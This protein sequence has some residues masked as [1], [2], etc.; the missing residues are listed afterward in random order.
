M[1]IVDHKRLVN[2]HLLKADYLFLY[3]KAIVLFD[4]FIF[5]IKIVKMDMSSQEGN[6]SIQLLATCVILAPKLLL[7]YHN[8]INN[9][10]EYPTRFVIL[11]TNFTTMFSKIGHLGI[12]NMLNKAKVN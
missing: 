6:V 1:L 2:E 7:K 5:L 9:K 11:T 8:K 3:Q 10:I 4:E 12:K